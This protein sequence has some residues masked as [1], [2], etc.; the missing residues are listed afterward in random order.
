MKFKE[1]TANPEKAIDKLGNIVFAN[2][3]YVLLNDSNV[4][5]SAGDAKSF[6][7]GFMS[8]THD[9]YADCTIEVRTHKIDGDNIKATLP[10]YI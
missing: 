6:L 2:K 7:T 9:Y 3:P 10:C 4:V 5:L 1:F 8:L